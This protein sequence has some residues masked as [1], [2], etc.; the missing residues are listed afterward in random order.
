MAV[1]LR[2]KSLNDASVVYG[3]VKKQI[4]GGRN[5]VGGGRLVQ[6]GTGH[7]EGL[8]GMQNQLQQCPH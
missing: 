4:G 1:G 5:G 3:F 6:E 2:A 8:V 7:I